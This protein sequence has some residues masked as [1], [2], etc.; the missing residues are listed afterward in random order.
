MSEPP[1]RLRRWLVPA[2]LS[3]LLLLVVGV[4]VFWGDLV[5]TALDPKVPFQTYDPPPA[6]DY[7]QASA[8]YLRPSPGDA[9]AADVFF[10]A[11]TTYDGGRN[12]NAR[13]DHPRANRQFRE[14]M[15]PNYVGPFVMVGRIYAPRYR[16]ASLYSLTTLREDAREA[17]QFAYRDV[18]AA[19]RSYL[20]RDNGGRPFLIVG[21]EQGGTLAARLIAEEVAPDPALK[22]RMVAAYLI[23]AVTP[24]DAPV[25]P[26]CIRRGQTGCLA[27]WAAVYEG[28]FDAAQRLLERA[29]VWNDKG[30]LVNITPRPALCFNPVFGAVTQAPAPAR[31]HLGAANATGL[32]WGARP[33]FMARQV[34]ARCEGGVL[35]VTRPRSNSLKKTGDWA[36][37]RKVPGFNLF[38]AD[39]EAD[40]KQR[41][42]AWLAG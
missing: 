12:W 9:A 35:R 34:A 10:V 24:A 22:A 16:Q 31:L 6:P 8:W 30:E 18:R 32:E 29:L 15:A 27:A 36:D 28:D 14:V 25:A 7:A 1:R 19:F 40:A 21:V 17:R 3:L 41:L 26:P 2:F 39:V 20:A 11:P 38:Y 37:R 4:V 5:S 42:A 13:I 33:A 23:D